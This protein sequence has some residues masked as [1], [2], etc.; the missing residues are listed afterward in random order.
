[1][2]KIILGAASKIFLALALLLENLI[3]HYLGNG[4]LPSFLVY[5]HGP[6]LQN[7]YCRLSKTSR[8]PWSAGGA[9]KILVDRATALKIQVITVT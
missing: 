1:M 7:F 2:A 5:F 9:K 8:L 4:I 3:F 6:E